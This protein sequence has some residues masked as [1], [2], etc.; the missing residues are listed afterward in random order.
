M[1]ELSETALM[2]FYYKPVFPGIWVGLT[3]AGWVHPKEEIGRLQFLASSHKGRRL[4]LNHPQNSWSI[5]DIFECS[6]SAALPSVTDV[7]LLPQQQHLG[8]TPEGPESIP[9]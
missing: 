1:L 6:V 4:F 3:P 8:K 9:F 7:G 5:L 2:D